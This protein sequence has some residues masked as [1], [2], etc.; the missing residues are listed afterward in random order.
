MK[1]DGAIFDMDG[2][3]VDSLYVWDFLWSELGRIYLG[4]DSFRPGKESDKTVRT[5]ILDDA[6]E[7]IHKTC[8]IGNSGAELLETA[9][10]IILTFYKEKVELKKGAAELL[11]YLD[12]RGVKMC[13]ASAT[14]P[15]L[16][17]IALEHCK[18]KKYFSKIFSCREIGKGKESPDIY[19]AALNYL[20]TGAE[21]TWVFEDSFVALDTV[22]K[23]GLHTVGIYDKNNFDNDKSEQIS[24]LYVADG[25]SLAKFIL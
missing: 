8:S 2:T 19:I 17:E 21:R 18:I 15:D 10:D 25:E 1:I 22:S 6:M 16:I 24:D 7:Y 23:M 14:A 9:N 3:L 5:M 13:V 11:G 4:D 12:E 20:Q